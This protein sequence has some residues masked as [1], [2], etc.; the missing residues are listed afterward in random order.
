MCWGI[1]KIHA[2]PGVQCE[3]ADSQNGGGWKG[4]QAPHNWIS[5]GDHLVQP[6]LF[7]AGCLGPPPIRF[8]VSPLMETPLPLWATCASVRPPSQEKS[9]FLRSDGISCVL[10][11]AF[12]TVSGQSGEMSGSLFLTPPPP[13]SPSRY[14]YL[15]KSNGNTSN[16]TPQIKDQATVSFTERAWVHERLTEDFTV[17]DNVMNTLGWK[18]G[19]DSPC[20]SFW[21]CVTW[22]SGGA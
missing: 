20:L 15:W 19:E 1:C 14:L 17:S 11:H 7:R 5:S 16:F 18:P 12:C 8:W 4:P 6:H 10:T 9:V 2:A 3:I 13:S 21:R 22:H